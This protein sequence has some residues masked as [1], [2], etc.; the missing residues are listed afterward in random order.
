M[1]QAGFYHISPIGEHGIE[2]G[3]MDR[4]NQYLAL[5][6]T[7]VRQLYFCLN[8][9]RIGVLGFGHRD[10]KGKVLVKA[11]A[12]KS[13]GKGIISGFQCSLCKVNIV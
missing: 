3:Q 9:V 1:D 7:A 5:S 6:V 2:G 13:G 4:I 10:F 8:A 11:Q 12:V